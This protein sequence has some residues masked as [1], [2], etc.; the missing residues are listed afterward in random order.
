MIEYLLQL[1]QNNSKLKRYQF[2]ISEILSYDISILIDY[3]FEPEPN[4]PN[5]ELQE[6]Q[7]QQLLPL[8]FQPFQTDYLNYTQVGYLTKIIESIIRK[9]GN[10]LW[11]WFD[12]NKS[13]LDH[14]IKH[15]DV[16]HVTSI[17]FHLIMCEQTFNHHI[18]QRIYLLQRVHKI[19]LNKIHNYEI[20][21][22]SCEL[23]IQICNTTQQQFMQQIENPEQFYISACDTGFVEFLNI[24]I[25]LLQQRQ[26]EQEN[27]YSKYNYIALNIHRSFSYEYLN[28]AFNSTLNVIQTTLGQFKLSLLTIYHLLLKTEDSK[29]LNLIHHIQIYKD[30]Y[31]YIIKFEFN[32]QLQIQF[33]QITTF[34]FKTKSLSWIQELIKNDL[35]EFISTHNTQTKSIIGQIKYP[36]NRGYFGILSQLSYELE[37]HIYESTNWNYYKQN[38]LQQLK[39][40]E[41]NYYFGVNPKSNDLEQISINTK[42]NFQY[43][44]YVKHDPIEIE[45]NNNKQNNNEIEQ[46]LNAKLRLSFPIKTLLSFSDMNSKVVPIQSVYNNGNNTES[47]NLESDSLDITELKKKKICSSQNEYLIDNKE[48]NSIQIIEDKNATDI[49]NVNQNDNLQ[50]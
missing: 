26:S 8:L 28:F 12:N 19:L 9:R 18:T 34:I 43:V 49:I 32:N 16:Y 38:I 31:K 21:H 50:Y 6:Q 48:S 30:L 20:V 45:L 33:N 17:L 13:I 25:A 1:D 29:L 7:R 14:L 5:Y 4:I 10:S 24:I 2:L 41:Q 36:I 37:E 47:Q 11:S 40:I 39:N 22:N 44:S 27:D 42:E 46:I 35:F 3:L 15:L 23:L